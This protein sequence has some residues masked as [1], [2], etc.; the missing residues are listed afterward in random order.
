MLEVLFTD[1]VAHKT[2]QVY[3]NSVYPNLDFVLT[4]HDPDFYRKSLLIFV[5]LPCLIS[6]DSLVNVVL[7]TNLRFELISCYKIHSS[8]KIA[9]ALVIFIIIFGRP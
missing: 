1:S 6:N 8:L 7:L 3:E 9:Q 5:F 4:T 2:Y